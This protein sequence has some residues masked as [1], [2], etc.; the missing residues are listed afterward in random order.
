[1]PGTRRR[2]K[3]GIVP[4]TMYKDWTA[5]VI[6]TLVV[7]FYLFRNYRMKINLRKEDFGLFEKL[8]S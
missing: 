7:F 3:L 6:D 2:D 8:R 1:L 5:E 4:S